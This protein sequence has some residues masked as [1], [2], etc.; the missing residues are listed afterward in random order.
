MCIRDSLYGGL[1]IGIGLLALLVAPAVA[2]IEHLYV[3]LHP[4]L[5]GSLLAL[6]LVRLALSLLALLAPTCLM[7]G[8]LPA[9][10]VLLRRADRSRGET[11]ALHRDLGRLYGL[12][13]LGAVAGTV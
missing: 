13:T 4:H 8:T 5:S 2:G 12:N 9:L 3:A 11:T 1:E 7:G 10:T 6:S